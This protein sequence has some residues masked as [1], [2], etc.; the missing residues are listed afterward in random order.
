MENIDM[1]ISIAAMRGK[2]CDLYCPYRED[3]DYFQPCGC[4]KIKERK[5]CF[6]KDFVTYMLNE[7]KRGKQQ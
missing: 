5:Q 3:V 4:E 7:I 6:A 1:R 2:W